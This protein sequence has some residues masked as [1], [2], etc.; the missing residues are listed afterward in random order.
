MLVRLGRL[1]AA[2][3]LARAL[4]VL[5]AAELA[6]AADLAG[7]DTDAAAALPTCWSPRASSA[8]GAR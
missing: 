5:E 1:P 6:Q 2:R 8:R 7:L 3:R 4:A